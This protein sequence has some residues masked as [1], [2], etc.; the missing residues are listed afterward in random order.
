MATPTPGS[1]FPT[2]AD[3]P[4]PSETTLAR[5]LMWAAICGGLGGLFAAIA[6]VTV[7]FIFLM[8]ILALIA[9]ASTN[10]TLNDAFGGFPNPLTD[11]PLDFIWLL[12]RIAAVAAVLSMGSL[13]A[14]RLNAT[15]RCWAPIKQGL[16]AA[17][18]TYVAISALASVLGSLGQ[19]IIATW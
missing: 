12:L 7:L 14:I 8:G 13:L 9:A 16:A 15:V 19:A 4:A 6:A 18:T 1:P 2:V 17:A 11:I 5:P 10:T 3:Q